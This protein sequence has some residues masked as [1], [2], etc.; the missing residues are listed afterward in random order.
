MPGSVDLGVTDHG[1]RASGEQAAQIAVALLTDTA[2]LLLTT[3]RG[4]LRHQSDPG[5]QLPE[6]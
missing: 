3:A 2:E 6:D 4:L 1:E 5:G